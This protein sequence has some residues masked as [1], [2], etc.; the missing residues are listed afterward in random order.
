MDLRVLLLNAI[1]EHKKLKTNGAHFGY[2]KTC[3]I[4]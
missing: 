2:T 3:L 4:L 1:K